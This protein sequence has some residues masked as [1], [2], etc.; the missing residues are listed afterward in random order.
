MAVSRSLVVD[1]DSK[2]ILIDNV[3]ENSSM[4]LIEH[5]VYNNLDHDIPIRF[6]N[7]EFD[8]KIVDSDL[9]SDSDFQRKDYIR[10][11]YD[12]DL[13]PVYLINQSY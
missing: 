1:S 6:L 12:S 10:K 9:L 2:M 13:N 5:R 7:L 11:Y 3:Y 4:C 8:F